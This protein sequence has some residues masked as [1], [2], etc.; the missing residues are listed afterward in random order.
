MFRDEHPACARKARDE[1]ASALVSIT[2]V[3]KH[4]VLDRKISSEIEKLY[5]A[6]A[7]ESGMTSPTLTALM[8]EL[9]SE[10]NSLIKKAGEDK[11]AIFDAILAGWSEAARQRATTE[12]PLDLA[13]HEGIVRIISVLDLPNSFSGIALTTSGVNMNGPYCRSLPARTDLLYQVEC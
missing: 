2:E 11:R 10:L 7:T 8:S 13:E 5:R 6:S 4:A 9:Q 3:M 12:P 1:R